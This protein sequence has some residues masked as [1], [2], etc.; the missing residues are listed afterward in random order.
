MERIE[1][2]LAECRQ[3]YERHFQRQLPKDLP[4][5]EAAMLVYEELGAAL[6][7]EEIRVMREKGSK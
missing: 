1:L 6:V 3:L 7:R 2:T 5:K 4:Y